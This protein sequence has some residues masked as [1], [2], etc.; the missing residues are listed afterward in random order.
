MRLRRAAAAANNNQQPLHCC[1]VGGMMWLIAAL[2]LT[3]KAWSLCSSAS[4]PK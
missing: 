1:G 2:S 4:L 3:L